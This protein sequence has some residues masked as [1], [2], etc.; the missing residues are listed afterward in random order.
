M[1][2]AREQSWFWE[3]AWLHMRKAGGSSRIPTR[4]TAWTV[5]EGARVYHLL[6]GPTV[7]ASGGIVVPG[8]QLEPEA[9]IIARELE[10]LGVPHDHIVLDSSS[11]NTHEQSLRMETLVG[12]GTR[13]VLVTTPMHMPRAVALFRARGL[14][15]VPSPSALAFRPPDLPKLLWLAPNP[16]SLWAS[17]LAMYQ[18]HGV[19]TRLDPRLALPGRHRAVRQA[20]GFRRWALDDA[21]GAPGPS[22][23]RRAPRAP[24]SSRHRSPTA[25]A[26][27]V[28]AV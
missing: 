11:V 13:M 1:H 9:D 2:G 16:D 4:Q 24:G 5:L 15:V 17:R 6:D 21:Q 14:D 18:V 27:V 8:I 7:I 25:S 22:R 10:R 3:T 26:S 12:H 19:R 28:S 20:L 23:H